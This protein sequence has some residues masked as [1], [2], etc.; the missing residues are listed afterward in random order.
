MAL[1]GWQKLHEE[2]GK[3]PW[4]D[5]FGPAINLAR[6]GFPVT[7]DLAEAIRQENVTRQDPLFAETYA[8]N[9]TKLVEGDTGSFI[10]VLL[11]WQA[12]DGIISHSAYRTRYADTLEKIA[13]S[14]ADAFYSGEIGQSIID[15]VQ[16]TGGI[17]T[18]QDLANYTAIE[19]EPLSITYRNTKIFSTVAPSSG[20]VV[21][22]A[23]K[24]CNCAYY[25][26]MAH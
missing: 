13:K 19:R 18:L 1:L 9:G 25:V 23:L 21:L 2:H 11:S 26:F 22:S 8:P 20:S 14:G 24:V 15:T 7:I 12:P 17:M 5:L 4:S 16:N 6:N 3:L 10:R